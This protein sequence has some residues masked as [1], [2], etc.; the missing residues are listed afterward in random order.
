MAIRI[1]SQSDYLVTDVALELPCDIQEVDH[2]MKEMRAN[3]RVVAMYADGGVTGVTLEQRKRVRAGAAEDK[4][5][6]IVGVVSREF[7]GH[8]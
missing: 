5:R 3:G 7:N 6:E 1:K 8:H 4:V 2:L